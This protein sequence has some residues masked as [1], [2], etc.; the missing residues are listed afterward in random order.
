MNIR[1]LH[2]FWCCLQN[3]IFEHTRVLCN[4]VHWD[5]A[6]PTVCHAPLESTRASSLRE[7]SLCHYLDKHLDKYNT[8]VMKQAWLFRIQIFLECSGRTILFNRL[9]GQAGVMHQRT[10]N[11]QSCCTKTIFLSLVHQRKLCGH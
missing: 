5:I 9:F 11:Y 2:I 6:E 8:V 7:I 10:Q 1:H 3:N 4:F